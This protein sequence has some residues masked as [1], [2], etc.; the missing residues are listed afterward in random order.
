MTATQRY[1][2]R[3]LSHFVGRGRPEPEQYDILVQ[4][5]LNTGWI[6][7]GPN[8][9]PKAQRGVGLDMSKPISTDEA[10]KYQVVCFCDIPE[11][12]LSLHTKKYSRFGL[13]FPKQFLIEKGACPVFYVANEGHVPVEALFRPG[14]FEN[15]IETALKTGSIDRALYFDTS[16]RAILDMLAGIDAI[17]C[18]EDR[19]YFKGVDAMEFKDRLQKLFGLSQLHIAAMLAEIKGNEQAMA[20]TR[21]VIDFLINH[22]FTFFKCFD[23]KRAIE[24]D[25]HYYMEREWRLG[26]NLQFSLQDVS[27]VFFPRK[28]AQQF[29]SDL[30]HYFGQVSF[31]D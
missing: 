20:S 7:H 6:T 25:R 28:Y 22:V 24:D 11:P 3:D 19:R 4:K 30:P 17:A 15:R 27:R 1:V 5:I 14:D 8:H 23:A 10:I 29:R 31:L 18:P 9:D 2:S 16:V 13:A 26:N 12:D 21:M